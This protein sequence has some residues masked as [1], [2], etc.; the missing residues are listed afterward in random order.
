MAV[1]VTGEK[2]LL[3]CG[4]VTIGTVPVGLTRGG[5]AFLVER[6]YREVA[7]DCDLGPVKGRIVIDRETA[8]LTVNALEMFN[9]TDMTLYYP[10]LNLD[11]DEVAFKN[12]L[13]SVLKLNDADYNP[14]V[15]FVGKT[16][17]GKAVTIEVTNAINMANLE[18]VFEEKNE[19]VPAIEFT[20]TYLEDTRLT[21]PTWS[22]VFATA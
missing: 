6:E 1:K 9:S 18:W 12:T 4:V 11:V 16:K 15:K 14:S 19:V 8:K 5:S 22:V 20:G 7:A 2:I 17:D 13:K 10:G 21:E 3:G